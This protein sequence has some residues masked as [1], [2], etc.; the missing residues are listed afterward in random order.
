MENGGGGSPR[1]AFNEADLRSIQGE[2]RGSHDP[3]CCSRGGDVISKQHLRTQTRTNWRVTQ[4]AAIDG[5]RIKIVVGDKIGTAAGDTGCC[6]SEHDVVIGAI[7][8]SVRIEGK[9]GRIPK[10]RKA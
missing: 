5:V 8:R 2:N 1:N 4:P 6:Q 7:G 10:W 3:A 9:L